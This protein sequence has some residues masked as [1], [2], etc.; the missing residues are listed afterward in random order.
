[1][2]VADRGDP[3]LRETCRRPRHMAR[4]TFPLADSNVLVRAALGQP[5]PGIRGRDAWNRYSR[6][7]AAAGDCQR[8]VRLPGRARLARAPGSAADVRCVI[9]SS[10]DDHRVRRLRTVGN[11]RQATQCL[12]EYFA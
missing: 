2:A 1:M 12:L 4:V 8:L 7:V 3:E 6:R 9:E 10:L 11:L 5:L